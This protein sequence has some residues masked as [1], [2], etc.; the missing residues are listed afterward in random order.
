MADGTHVLGSPDMD[1]ETYTALQQMI[2]LAKK[3]K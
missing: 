3:M 2:Q 1:S